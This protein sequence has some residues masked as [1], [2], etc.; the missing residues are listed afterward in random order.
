[1]SCLRVPNPQSVALGL[2][3]K[4]ASHCCERVLSGCTRH[5]ARLI[6]MARSSGII[7][8][9]MYFVTVRTARPAVVGLE[10][11]DEGRVAADRLGPER[12]HRVALVEHDLADAA[13]G[14][15]EGQR[16]RVVGIAGHGQF[17]AVGGAQILADGDQ[18]VERASWILRFVIGHLV[19]DRAVGDRRR[20][21]VVVVEAQREVAVVALQSRA[22]RCS[23]SARSMVATVSSASG[24]LK[25]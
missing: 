23:R 12:E 21:G 9:L 19:V 22:R 2:K 1:M 17:V 6:P 8:R 4:S 14:G 20:Q 5:A 18:V 10:A 7:V 16:P 3:P 25:S 24:L 13:L 15:V 11:P